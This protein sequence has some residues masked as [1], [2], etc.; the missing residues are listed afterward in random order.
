MSE[1]SK[2][3]ISKE[4]LLKNRKSVHQ[5]KGKPGGKVEQKEEEGLL[6]A[7]D[8]KVMITNDYLIIFYLET[9]DNVKKP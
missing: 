1:A 4:D 3:S 7:K 9:N 6:F 8:P 5:S 2:L